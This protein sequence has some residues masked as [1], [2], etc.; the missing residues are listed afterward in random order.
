MEQEHL[1]NLD[2]LPQH[3][4]IIMDG[5]G[6]WARERGED[7]IVGHKYGVDSVRKVVE[8]CTEIGIKYLTLY[9]FS[10]ENWNRPKYEVDALMTLL[11]SA[12]SK[13]LPDL[14]KNGVRL[15]VIGDIESLP[16]VCQDEL[17][18]G[19]A[20]LANGTG[21]T[22]IL[23]LSYSSKWEIAEMVKAL[24]QK[25]KDG[26]I[27][28]DDINDE[29]ISNHLNTAGIPDPELLIR[30]SGEQ[31]ISNFL[32]YQIAYSEFYFTDI[33]WPDFGKEQLVDAILDYQ[34][35][36]RRFGKTSAQIN[37]Q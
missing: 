17:K 12:L 7:R 8:A 27:S 4:A 22:L 29:M 21:V 23:A 13:E 32:L 34:Q 30:T 10:T 9:A 2:K 14:K 28:I 3:I 24:A 15:Q 35:R 1:I 37:Q 19:I 16:Q 18:A 5:N 20:D 11:V 33:N 25:A 26:T 31:R 6:R 36:E